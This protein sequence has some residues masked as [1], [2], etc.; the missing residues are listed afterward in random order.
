MP[1][2]VVIVAVHVH[3]IIV[4]RLCIAVVC[5][6]LLRCQFLFVDEQRFQESIAQQTHRGHCV[7]LKSGQL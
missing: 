3:I 7:R 4:V 6:V 1:A 5:I 2:L